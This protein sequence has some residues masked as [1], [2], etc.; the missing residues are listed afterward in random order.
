MVFERGILQLLISLLLLDN[1]E[2]EG[3]GLDL[4]L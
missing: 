3:G 1:I 2:N 4:D